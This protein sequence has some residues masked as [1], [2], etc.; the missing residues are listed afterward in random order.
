VTTRRRR[1]TLGDVEDTRHL[2]PSSAEGDRVTA[3]ERPRLALTDSLM[4]YGGPSGTAE[5]T[6][7]V[8][9]GLNRA[10]DVLPDDSVTTDAMAVVEQDYRHWLVRWVLAEQ[11]GAPV[12]RRLDVEARGRQTPPG[13]ITAD[14]LRELSPTSVTASAALEPQDGDDFLA[15]L[16]RW[17]RQEVAAQDQPEGARPRGRPPLSDAHLAAVSIAYLQEL[18]RG[19]G[20]LERLEQR[21]DRRPATMRDQVHIA[22]KRGFLTD[23]TSQGKKGGAPG[24]ALLAFLH[25]AKEESSS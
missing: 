7:R 21:F 8:R 2:P 3:E 20:L 16:S 5:E 25:A 10:N 18:P 23:N 22:R 24:P 6:A 15:L 19:R 11:N 9:A 4:A 14:L 17:A 12:V 1:A 13:G